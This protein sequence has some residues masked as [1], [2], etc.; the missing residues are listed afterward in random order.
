MGLVDDITVTVVA[1]HGLESDGLDTAAGVLG[2]GR[3][4]ALM[5]RTPSPR[6]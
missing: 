2:A 3:G 4:L 6:L 1:P 5:S